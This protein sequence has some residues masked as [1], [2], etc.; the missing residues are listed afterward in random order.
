[1]N[2][3]NHDTIYDILGILNK[4]AI[5]TRE[6][7]KIEMAIMRHN[8]I[9]LKDYKAEESLKQSEFINKMIHKGLNPNS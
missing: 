4:T 8:N 3:L 5:G 9:L 1:M 7:Y 2:G 6:M